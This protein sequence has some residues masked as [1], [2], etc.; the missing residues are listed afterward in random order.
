MSGG[1]GMTRARETRA[2]QNSAGDSINC[3][4]IVAFSL[5]SYREALTVFFVQDDYGWLVHSR[6]PGLAEYFRSFVT[7]NPWGTYRPLTQETFFYLGQKLFGM[8]P[9][10]Y[11]I[12][13]ILAHLA[14]AV[15]VYAIVR[16]FCDRASSAI[17][18]LL[19]AAHGA[20]MTALYWI[21]AF[22]EPAAMLFILTSFFLFIQYARRRRS[23]FYLL[24]LI[25]AALGIMSKESALTLPLVLT[26]YSLLFPGYNSGRRRGFLVLVPYYLLSVAYGVCRLS[27]SEVPVSPYSMTFGKETW[28]NFLT[29][30][31]WLGGI[32]E[33]L[34]Q[35]QGWTAEWVY[36]VTALFSAVLVTV[37]FLISRNRRTAIFAILW[38]AAAFQPFLYFSGHNQAYYLAPVLAGFS[39]LVASAITSRG[40]GWSWKSLPVVGLVAVI[41]WLAQGTLRTEGRWFAERSWKRRDLIDKIRLIDRQVPKDKTAFV[42][43]IR[44]DDFESFEKGSVFKVYGF[45]N[46]RLIF[47]LPELDPDLPMQIQQLK[48]SGRLL[49]TFCYV[50]S[51]SRVLDET[52]TF[53]ESPNAFLVGRMAPISQRPEIT[54]EVKPTMV[55]RGRDT[56]VIRVQNFDGP[57]IDLL[58][59]I[60]GQLMPPLI[61]W[62]LDSAGTATVFVDTTTQTGSYDFKAIRDSR[63]PGN[64]G[65]IR[66]HASVVVQ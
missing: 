48:S 22:P 66:V 58:Y 35:K 11:H 15:L 50:I 26:G 12:V 9:L 6:F 63:A 2:W 46:S 27:A 25:S 62:P 19:Y 47:A 43:G 38:M 30:L 7:F 16:Q 21:S 33:G 31:S 44:P 39:L 55:R 3:L 49:A 28:A 5:V 37:L 10:S 41:L 17:G 52:A 8:E 13:A 54:L 61:T 20:H 59:A 29:Y 51:G 32:S 65:W 53:R 42:F 14:A 56:L 60:D 24:S 40:G 36:P 1:H 18:S 57:A 45:S 4:I 23:L 34:A 64:A